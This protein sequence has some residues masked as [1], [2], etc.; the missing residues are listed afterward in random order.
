MNTR[1]NLILAFAAFGLSAGAVEVTIN[2]GGLKDAI[3]ENTEAT[4][5][6]V[7]GTMNAADFDFIGESMPALTALDISKTTINAYSGDAVIMGR[8]DFAANTLPA[9][10][11]M[12]S[13][14]TEIKLPETLV[15][16][17]EAALSS[18]PLTSI[19][20]P[21]TVTTIG[22]GAFSDCDQLT[23]VEIPSTVTSL[24]SHAF[25]GCDR[26][27]SVKIGN[28]IVSI[29]EATFARCYS[30][31]AVTLPSS[32]KTIG[33][34]AFKSCKAVTGITFPTSL[35]SIGDYAF[36]AT[37]LTG[38]NLSGNAAMTSI[39][40]WAFANCTD[41]TAVTLN[42]KI[43]SIGKGAFFD[44]PNLFEFNMPASCT[45]VKEYVFKGTNTIDTTSVVHSGITT[46]NAYAMAGWN[47]VT[48][49]TLPSSLSYIGDNAC[50]NWSSLTR[51]NA[52]SLTVVPELGNDVWEGVDQAAATLSVN[53]RL[54]TEFVEADQWKEFN[55]TVPTSV[56][57]ILADETGNSITAYFTGYNLTVK[58]TAE[59]A[60]L[61]IYDSSGRQYVYTAPQAEEVTID[62]GAWDCRIYIVAATLSDGTSSTVK[63]AR[64]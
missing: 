52:E 21:A 49:F 11:L 14:L 58:A 5:L 1:L 42:D 56:E 50:E 22:M 16:I 25:L 15:E 10:S 23:S 31:S 35:T 53:G 29:N 46:I 64:R 33:D 13:S 4:T 40:E 20:I 39:G 32:L 59:I 28:G 62:T 47:H 26:L 30:L 41:L 19:T 61:R 37:G 12:G 63:I 17:G 8:T 44:D 36:Q 3:G 54:Y 27:E 55:I 9:Y 60:D 6:T 2:A 51:L 18:T 45:E 24:A 57:T 34:A 7:S 48:T 38:I 43:S